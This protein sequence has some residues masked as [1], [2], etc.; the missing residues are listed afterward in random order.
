MVTTEKTLIL[1][2]VFVQLN[3][4]WY[5]GKRRF[6][7][8]GGTASSKT[9]SA[10][11]FLKLLLENY[12]EPILATVT[13][14][15]MP[16]L[17]RGA[18]RDFLNIM[19]DEIIQSCWNKTDFIYTFPKSGCKL[20][21]VSADQPA[22]LRGGRR[23]ILFCNEANNIARDSFREAD[24]RT[25]LFTIADWNP[26]SEFW[27]HD[28]RWYDDLENVY[29]AGITYRD[30]PEAVSETT[31]KDIE[32]YAD[33]DPNWYR[34][35]G[36]G[37]LGRLEGLV[38]P[39]F[40]QVDGLPGGDYF[41]GLDWGYSVDPTVLVK[42]VI[43]GENLYSQEMFYDDSGLT[44]DMISRKIDL[45]KVKRNELIFPDPNEPKSAE[46]LRK[47]GWNVQET[48]K[49]AGSVEYGTQ[50][51]NQYYQHWTKDSLNCIK[52]QRNCRYIE[53]RQH[54]GRFTEKTTHQWSHGMDARRYAVASYKQGM[55]NPYP[56]GKSER[57]LAGVTRQ[58]VSYPSNFRR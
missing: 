39:N 45:C 52:E 42:N 34:V 38:Y 11:Q 43:I 18:I 3:D 53:D 25:R 7:V 8:E 13:S 19:G 1:T 15:S 20:E 41:Y 54:P 36:L 9:W 10:M 33:R 57:R 58:R 46:E 55:G 50:K 6:F 47:L 51:V 4:A 35:Y 56:S 44:N 26:V 40:K 30:A 5:G 16:H 48:V 37:L 31:I 23:E 29:V 22:K 2:T 12:K 49:G 17:K 21:F 27:F 14:E 28:E 32:K 24:M